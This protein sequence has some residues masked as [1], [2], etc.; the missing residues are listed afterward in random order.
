MFKFISNIDFCLNAS[1]CF[2]VTSILFIIAVRQKKTTQPYQLALRLGTT[3][4]ALVSHAPPLV[5]QRKTTQYDL[6]QGPLSSCS[7]C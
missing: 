2:L 5:K 3:T 4:S 1:I 6:F 7:P